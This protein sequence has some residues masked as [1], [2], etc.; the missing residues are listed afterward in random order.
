MY[1]ESTVMV[2]Y[3]SLDPL[4]KRK[5]LGPGK[6][7][8]MRFIGAIEFRIKTITGVEV[9]MPI[10]VGKVLWICSLHRPSGAP[11]TLCVG[12]LCAAE[13]PKS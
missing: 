12:A 13:L 2:M 6:C 5:V 3:S 9:D 11:G 10:A 4:H 7:Q 8:S 1:T